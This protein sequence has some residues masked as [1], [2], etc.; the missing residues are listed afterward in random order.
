M[1]ITAIANNFR[2]TFLPL[3]QNRTNLLQAVL[4]AIIYCGKTQGSNHLSFDSRTRD[5]VYCRDSR[6]IAPNLVVYVINFD[7]FVVSAY[8]ELELTPQN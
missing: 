8:Y 7:E 3:V 1:M 4:L 2:N 5:R 6:A